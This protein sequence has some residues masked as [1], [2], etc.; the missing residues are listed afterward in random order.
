[1]TPVGGAK[2][3]ARG[4]IVRRNAAIPKGG[5]K[6]LR[7]DVATGKAGTKKLISVRARVQLRV[8]STAT[9]GFKK[10]AGATFV[11]A[12]GALM[13]TLT[14]SGAW[15][16]EAGATTVASGAITGW[17][18]EDP[19]LVRLSYRP[20]KG[21]VTLVVDGASYRVRA[22]RGAIDVS[23]SPGKNKVSL[24]SGEL[25]HL[26][27]G[28]RH[29]ADILKAHWTIITAEARQLMAALFPTRNPFVWP[30]DRF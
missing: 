1:M 23:A 28:Y 17:K 9:I 6:V 30:F 4:V 7:A 13:A 10:K 2:W 8:K 18:A 12:P 15:T 16:V 11:G 26:V 22:N 3:R 19:H 20:K 21:T 14:R 25:M 29:L 27:T 5:S 24:S